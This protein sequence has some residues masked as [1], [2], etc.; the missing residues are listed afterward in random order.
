MP[1]DPRTQYQKMLAGELHAV[2]D[3]EIEAKAERAAEL[4]SAFNALPMSEMDKRIALLQRA[5]RRY[6]PGLM[7]SPVHWTYGHIEIGAGCFFN[8]ECQFLDDAPITIG[9]RVA[10]GPRVQFITIGHPVNAEERT[11]RDADGN[12]ERGA[13]SRAS[14]IVVEDQVWIGASAIIL[15]G[16]T[17]GA[18]STIGAGSVVTKSIPPDVLAAGNPCRVTKSI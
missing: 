6:E 11:R 12:V 5:L 2:P 1:D 10:V 4:L 7:M 8:I 18:R 3:P 15:S 13:M 9:T 16:V 14:P 17:I